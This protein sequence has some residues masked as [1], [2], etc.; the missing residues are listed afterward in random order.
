LSNRH[1]WTQHKGRYKQHTI[2]YNK[3]ITCLDEEW[4]QGK[5][6]G[7]LRAIV[8]REIL[9]MQLKNNFRKGCHIFV[10]HMEEAAKDKVASIEGHP[11]LRDFEDVFRKIINTK[12]RH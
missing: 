2:C 9:V 12:E 6:Q 8:V 5:I 7:I 4:K 11:V 3:T 10:A 1:E